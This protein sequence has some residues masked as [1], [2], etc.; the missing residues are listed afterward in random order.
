MTFIRAVDFIFYR[1]MGYLSDICVA[2]S[3][4]NV[5]VRCVGVDIF[6]NVVNSLY[7]KFVD[8]TDLTVLVSH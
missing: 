7:P 6:V 2:V 8:P 3:A 4:W 5:P 1:V